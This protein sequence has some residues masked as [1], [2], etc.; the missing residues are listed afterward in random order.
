MEQQKIRVMNTKTGKVI[1]ITKTAMDS[2]KKFN[3]FHNYMVV[4]SNPINAKKIE[5]PT[6]E[7]TPEPTQSFEFTN[8][9]ETNES[10]T[11]E[12][13]N[14]KPKRKYNKNPK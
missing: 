3:L 10:T 11:I 13:D 1:D 14:E 4:N 2:L 6:P 12:L 8:Y 9:V 7:P 5:T